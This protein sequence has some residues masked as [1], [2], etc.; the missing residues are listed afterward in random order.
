[1]SLFWRVFLVNAA[2]FVA[3]T[4]VLALSPATVS[5]PVELAEAVVLVVGLTAMLLINLLLV[6]LSFAP[7]ERLASLMGRID[8][9]QPGRRLDAAG[10]REV[11]ELGRAFND[12]LERLE[13]ERRESGRRAL[14]A[15]ETE[16]R[17]VAQELH[18]EV[19]QALTAVVL[20]LKSL[21]G[22]APPELRDELLYALEGARGSLEDVR[23]VA[24]RLRP[25]A[26]DDLGLTSALTALTSRFAQQTGISVQRSIGPLPPLD[27]EAELVL[28][29]IAQES[30]T[31]VARHADACQVA[32]ELLAADDC[33]FLRVV[34]DG[35]GLDGATEGDGI[36][37]MRE[38]AMLAGAE[39]TVGTPRGGGVEV[40]LRL[41]VSA[42]S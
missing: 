26:L 20:H 32:L 4:L 19:G 3:G 24:R 25:E 28:Y 22:Q 41:P 13:R 30:L 27:S 39:L 7:L 1:M 5:F 8:L 36:R 33:V 35:R 42:P 11:Q 18:D 29:R 37:G 38:R 6:R 9:R 31:N 34:D 23:R 14:A 16:R 2:I 17:R 10:P 21:A 40:S 12:M 15:Q